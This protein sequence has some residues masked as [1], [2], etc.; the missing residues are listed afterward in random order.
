MIEVEKDRGGRVE[1]VPRTKLRRLNRLGTDEHGSSSVLVRDC[2]LV[3][4]DVRL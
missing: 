3:C 4:G 2:I 1:V